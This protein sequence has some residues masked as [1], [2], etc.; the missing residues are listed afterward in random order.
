MNLF[1]SNCIQINTLLNSYTGW[2]AVN[3][4]PEEEKQ[5]LIL[6][7]VKRLEPS[8]AAL[9]HRQS[10]CS[11]LFSEPNELRNVFLCVYASVCV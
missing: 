9:I 2:V 4:E 7:F 6:N 5:N 1:L 3:M 8:L 11:D 10:D